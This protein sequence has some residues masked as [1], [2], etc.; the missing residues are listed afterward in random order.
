MISIANLIRKDVTFMF[1]KIMVA[2]D[3]SEVSENAAKIGIEIA[4]LS[5]GTVT[6]LYVVDILRL[7]H[8]P[9]YANFPGLASQL[10][11]LMHRE[12]AETTEKIEEMARAA[13]VSCNSMKGEGNPSNELLRISQEAGM[14]LLVIGKVGRSGLDKILM[15]SVA[16]KVV[17][18]S[19]IPVLLIPGAGQ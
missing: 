15:G 3:G 8:L 7:A 14:D 9:G 10:L 1:N 16:E 6:I 19:K 12:E 4:K 2:T 17:R 13:G 18:H 5:R 11:D